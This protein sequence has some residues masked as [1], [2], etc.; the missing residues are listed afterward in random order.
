M[1]LSCD[2]K[3]TLL[4]GIGMG[5]KPLTYI[6]IHY[7]KESKQ[8]KNQKLCDLRFR[9][10]IHEEKLLAPATFRGGRRESPKT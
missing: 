1:I 6:Q 2:K 9:E 10:E 7:T 5:F 3:K 4:P 8:V